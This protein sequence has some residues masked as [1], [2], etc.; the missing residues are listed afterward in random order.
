MNIFESQYIDFKEDWDGQSTSTEEKEDEIIFEID[1]QPKRQKFETKE[2]KKQFIEEYTK[3]KKTELCKNYQALGYCKF[4]NECSFAHG[5]EELQPKI[6]LHQKYK[7]KACIRY[8][9]DG[10]CP[11]G[12]RCQYLHNEIINRQEFEI[13]LISCYK[14]YGMKPP[15]SQKFLK[16]TERLDVQRFQQIF[17][18]MQKQG[19]SI[20]LYHRSNFFKN[21]E[22]QPISS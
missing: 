13:Y 1:V 21:L 6:H 8:F 7:T 10:F 11:Y 20:N 5:Q 17:K 16:T 15:I 4:G 18:N 12:I 22:N 19:L 14:K 2:Q 9:N 3:K